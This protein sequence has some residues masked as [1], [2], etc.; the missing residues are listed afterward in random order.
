MSNFIS[1]Y[2]AQFA[3]DKNLFFIAAI[4]IFSLVAII[5]PRSSWLFSFG[6]T[7]KE[8]AIAGTSY[9]IDDKSGND[10]Q[11]GLSPATAWKTISQINSR[12]FAAGDVVYLK[13]GGVFYGSVNIPRSNFSIG[14]YD[15][16]ANPIISGFTELTSWTNAGGGVYYSTQANIKYNCNL[17]TLNG[18]PQQVGRWPNADSGATKGY[19]AYESFNGNTQITDNQL[20]GTPNW[21]GAQVVIRKE[22][23]ILETDSVTAQSG[24]TITYAGL[25]PINPRNGVGPSNPTSIPATPSHAGFGFFFQ[26]DIRTLNSFG[27]WYFN[28]TLKRMSMYF[29]SNNPASYTIK[30]STV[31]TLINIGS[32]TNINISNVDFEGGNLCSVFTQDASDVTITNSNTA[33]AGAKGIFFWNTPNTL[34]DNCSFNY[35]ASNAID[36]T[37]R[38]APNVT[39][40]NTTVKNTATIL[41]MGN[42]FDIPE[43]DGIFVSVSTGAV[44][45]YCSVDTVGYIGIRFQGNGVRV[46]RNFVNFHDYLKDDGGGIYT[47]SNDGTTDR[48]VEY[49]IVLNGKGAPYGNFNPTHAEGIYCDGG[50]AGVTIRYNSIAYNSER[51]IY[52]ND[53]KD[54]PVYNNTCFSNGWNG[55]SNGTGGFGIQKHCGKNIF[56]FRVTNNIFWSQ[57]TYQGNFTY[58]NYG[59]TD[60]TIPTATDIGQALQKVGY[61]DSN[62]YCLT[63]TGAFDYSYQQVCDGAYTFPPAINFPTWTSWTGHDLKSK[64]FSFN[65]T[66]LFIYNKTKV[67]VTVPLSGNYVDVFGN[68]YPGTITLQPSTSAILTLTGAITNYWTLTT[69]T[70]GAGTG[71]VTKTPDSAQ[72]ING[73][74]AV[75]TAA[76]A[77]GSV[78]SVWSGDT[79]S[80]STS[81]TIPFYKNRN[82]IA[83]FNII[84]Y[85]LSTSVSP[86]GGGTVAGAGIYN[87]GTTA[88]LVA[89][90]APGY[91][92]TGWS[93]AA[94]GTNISTSVVMSA[95]KSVVANFALTPVSNY[96][97]KSFRRPKQG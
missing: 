45:E 20:P 24:G 64:T 23:Y 74:T 5:L 86:T 29:G 17:I 9:Y 83:N 32:K 16:G 27:E 58:F 62:Y 54:I 28:N 11:N 65:A 68:S 66:A 84:T 18:I 21:T 33:N 77:T 76:A 73:S 4:I 95:N 70:A 97:I 93:G 71:T 56:N 51:A 31:D 78:F 55:Y 85:S 39:V 13:R 43:M 49:N 38:Y 50:A 61:I 57:E 69:S 26:R 47:F 19:L 35:V 15:V 90:P 48:I 94:T 40:S 63:K 6:S 46:R 22:G 67:A 59:V 10:A 7:K 36:I 44:V 89:T 81:I 30:V 80:S 88:T 92:F 91:S 2:K 60:P 37:G 72:Y 42:F 52:M 34:I 8:V 41:G 1:K 12:T 25:P 79:T 87:Y 53:P 14:A 3:I 96:R 82:V 75:V